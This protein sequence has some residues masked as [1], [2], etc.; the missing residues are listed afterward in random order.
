MMN[1]TTCTASSLRDAIATHGGG[2]LSKGDNPAGSGKCCILEAHSVCI[3]IPWT[4]DPIENGTWD[5][6]P[7]NDI[8]VPGDIRTEH[9]VRVMEAYEGA[10][11]WPPA[12]QAEVAGRIALET[13]RKIVSELPGLPESAVEACRRA[14]SLV[15]AR[16]AVLYSSS[17]AIDTVSQT[18]SLQS[19]DLA[20]LSSN[21]GAYSAYIA[22]G[23]AVRAAAAAASSACSAE[24][25]AAEAGGDRIRVFVRAC[26]LW[27]AAAGGGYK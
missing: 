1:T 11:D 24:A 5:I 17:E 4:D 8:D 13:V 16:T 12:R 3:G 19:L 6:R 14:H 18:F 2:F 21:A 26:D 27:V 23:S 15:D 25:A 20:Q 22:K 9:M 10:T 7:L